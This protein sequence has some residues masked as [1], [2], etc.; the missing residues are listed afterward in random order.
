MQWPSHAGYSPSLPTFDHFQDT[1]M[2]WEHISCEWHQCLVGKTE[3][4][5]TNIKIVKVSPCSV[6]SSTGLPNVH[7]MKKKQKNNNLPLTIWNRNTCDTCISVGHLSKPLSIYLDI[8]IT[9][10]ARH[11]YSQA[12]TFHSCKLVVIKNWTVIR[13]GVWTLSVFS[14]SAPLSPLVS[15]ASAIAN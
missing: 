2:A 5:T 6:W 12:L 3:K 11:K 8:D 7:T 15:L 9:Y 14:F 10:G 13:P 4:S 1:K